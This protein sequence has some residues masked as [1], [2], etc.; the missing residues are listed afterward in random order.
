MD[1]D[2]GIAV[3]LKENR[4]WMSVAFFPPSGLARLAMSAETKHLS[5]IIPAYNAETFIAETLGCMDEFMRGLACSAELIVVDDGS[6][7]QTPNLIKAWAAKSKPYVVNIVSYE[8][9]KGK[10]AAVAAGIL[11]AS[12]KFRVFLDADLAYRPP[13][14]LKILQAL[15]DGAEV[16]V[17]SR[18]HPD[19]RYT[20]SPGF[21]HYLYTRHVAS[22]L[23]N[24]ALRHLIIPHCRD[25][26]AGLKGFS[27]KASEEIFSR[28]LIRGFA[29]DVEALYLA[30]KMGFSVREVP[31]D[32]QYLSEPT[33]VQF[34]S[35]GFGM[36]RDV[37]RIYRNSISGGYKLPA[38][39]PERRL[40]INAD[41]FAMT[42]E[43]SRGILKETI[44][45]WIS[46]NLDHNMLLSKDDPLAAHLE[47]TGERHF[48]MEDNPTAENIARLIH[49][50]AK[51]FG[52]SVSMVE[53]FESETSV[54]RFF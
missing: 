23:I 27:A 7:D 8:S 44:G 9:N 37:F 45:A 50:K 10:G 11:A 19:S 2:D 14:I 16:A 32:Y 34:V 54:A 20:I 22:R 48:K 12:G 18:V 4:V 36:L 13:Q 1:E 5:V 42:T 29:F 26:Q 51:E 28:Q 30:E 25:S 52:L 17:A 46:E 35:D 38:K 39:T 21:F 31:I 3:S 43:I 24:W 33:T 41:D 40:A 47:K 53:V 49:D 15:E 6:R